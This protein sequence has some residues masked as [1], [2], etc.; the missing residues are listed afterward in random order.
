MPTEPNL[1]PSPQDAGTLYRTIHD[2]ERG[3]KSLLA[4]KAALN[5]GV[6]E[7]LE[8]AVPAAQLAQELN[9]DPAMTLALCRLLEEMD[10][11]EK[12]PKGYRNTQQTQT[13]LRRSSLL[14][15]GNVVSCVRGGISIWEQ[16]E[17]LLINGPGDGS[18]GHGFAGEFIHALASETLTGELQ[19]TTDI[20]CSVPEFENVRTLLDLGGGH[21]LYSVALC[22]QNAKLQ[23]TVFDLPGLQEAAEHYAQKFD[24]KRVNFQAGNQFTDP[25]GDGY[26]AILLSYNPG[27]KTRAL[28]DK[29]HSA[30]AP[31]GLFITKH[32]YYAR[33]ERTKSP[34]LD[35]EWSMRGFSGVNKGPN[36]YRFK[37]D[38]S[39][40]EVLQYLTSHYEI[41]RIAGVHEFAP[42]RLGKIGDRLDS[43]LII[44]RKRQTPL[45]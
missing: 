40:E 43:Q 27:G 25:I 42:N 28:L 16:L 10:F 33:G 32:A 1:I 12:D 41:L 11:L 4:L 26:D 17:E 18:N 5:I 14:Y 20:I 35:M 13:F 6:F 3:Y 34:L 9:T 31:G 15:Q 39:H 37:N 29:I 30:L 2:A 45:E 22:Q 21:G 8:Q 24:G 19:K 7:H 23:A 36:I 38:M 44:G